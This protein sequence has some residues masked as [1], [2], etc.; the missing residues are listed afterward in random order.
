MY[1]AEF[2]RSARKEFAGLSKQDQKR[3]IN[4]IESL[5]K[6]PRARGVEK[7]R[8]SSYYRARTGSI[9]IIFDIRDEKI[10]IVIV[11]IGQRGDVYKVIP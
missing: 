4:K 2:T 5:R 7:V 11:K 6:N 10:L 9:R 1:D 8:S 3:V